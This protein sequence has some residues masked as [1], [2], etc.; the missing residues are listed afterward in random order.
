MHTCIQLPLLYQSMTL[1]LCKTLP[2]NLSCR[3]GK[4]F[5]RETLASYCM[6]SICIE[7]D[8]PKAGNN[9]FYFLYW[10]QFQLICIYNFIL[11]DCIAIFKMKSCM[12]M[13]KLNP[14]KKIELIIFSFWNINFYAN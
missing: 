8:I 12:H 7:A 11:N 2:G 6:L 14:V 9:Q 3:L 5:F 4:K 13:L 1:H 10:I